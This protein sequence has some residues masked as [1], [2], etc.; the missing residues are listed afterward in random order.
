MSA[1]FSIKNSYR[2]GSDRPFVLY[3]S[4]D[5]DFGINFGCKLFFNY[6]GI[7]TLSGCLFLHHLKQLRPGMVKIPICGDP[8]NFHVF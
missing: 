2:Y 4:A 3:P 1:I 6:Q 5:I 7:R 8:P